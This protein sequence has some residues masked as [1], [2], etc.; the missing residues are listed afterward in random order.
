ML[1]FDVREKLDHLSNVEIERTELRIARRGKVGRVKVISCTNFPQFIS[2]ATNE[3]QEGL[4]IKEDFDL[5]SFFEERVLIF[6]K[7]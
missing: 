2:G 1:N 4:R 6:V 5:V 7:K 3:L